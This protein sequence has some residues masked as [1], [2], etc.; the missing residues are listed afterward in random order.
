M[1]CPSVFKHVAFLHF[2]VFF[3]FQKEKR[4]KIRETKILHWTRPLS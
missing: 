4:E 2:V 1:L 3:S